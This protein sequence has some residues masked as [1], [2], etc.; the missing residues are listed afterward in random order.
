M[1][2]G[3]VTYH[4]SHNY[5]ALLQAIA[6]RKVL[7]DMGHN[8][9]YIDYWPDYHRQM[10]AL[11]S[12]KKM[13]RLSMRKKIG[14]LKAVLLKYCDRKKKIEKTLDFISRHILPYTKPVQEQYDT[15]VYG[16][17]QIWRK[18]SALKD[19]NGVYFGQDDFRTKRKV[20]FSASMGIL[21]TTVKD[22]ENIK[23]KL[24][25]FD[26][27]S[28]REGD[29]QQLLLSMGFRN[30]AHTL[31]PTLLLTAEEWDN[32]LGIEDERETGKY[33]LFY[34]LQDDTFDINQLKDFTEKHALKLK[35]ITQMGVSDES[36]KM[37]S[38]TDSRDFVTL[39]RNSEMVFTSS[40]HGLAF[41]II[42]GKPV[43]AAYERNSGRAASLLHLLGMD[44]CLLQ[45]MAQ[46]PASFPQVDYQKVLGLLSEEKNETIAILKR[47]IANV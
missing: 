42:Y 28:V 47:N 1:K 10:Y 36:G 38:I 3:I 9:T 2:I 29:L 30:V 17:D 19:Y 31:D 44:H 40:F 32:V 41:S 16:S 7:A 26:A 13:M 6:L 35:V 27:I 22:K 20:A 33:V 12:I 15:I 11:F 24:R 14:Y 37:H 21:P 39:I 46:I 18:Q 45:P 8:V 23:A 25:A 5:G 4:R 34:K 43:Y